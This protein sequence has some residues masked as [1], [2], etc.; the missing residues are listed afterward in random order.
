M[1]RIVVLGAGF[2]GLW[3]AIG[4][5]RKRDE[6]GA[7]GR[8]IE[9]RVVDRNPY[10]NIR[11]RNY[12]VDLSEVA[13]PLGQLL[14]PIG[15]THGLGE[16]EAID[17]ARREISL[18]TSDG[19]ETL[20]YDRLVLA[21]GS[22][23]T[24]P[25]IPGLADHAFDVDT[26]IA[27]LRLEDHLVSLGRSVPSPGR[28]TVVVVGAG[29]TGI[30]VAAEMPDRLARAGITGSRCIILVDPN[31]TVGATIGAHARPVIETALSALDI[32][33][34]LGARV[35]SVEA[36]GVQLSSGEFIPAQ[37][38]IWCAGLRASRLAASLPGA[39]DRLGRL[40]VDPFMRVADLPCV[41]AAGDVAS[42]VVDGLHP[43][44]MSCQF[45]RP[46]GRFAGHNVVADLLG[47][48][49]LPL[50]IDWYVTVLDLG[51]WGALYTEGWDREVRTTGA[52]AKATKQT[53]NRKRIYPP[54]NGSKD[55]LFAAAAP[56]V[57]TPPP[58]YGAR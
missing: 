18:V 35:A 3:A 49:M 54:L 56:T 33:T 7:A 20:G 14:D 37:T 24:R 26:Y 43:T 8:D 28:S 22:E 11:V 42:S 55:E 19:E 29:F 50:R 30:E 17:P 27:A 38:V 51:S 34:R 10:H 44:V 47:L 21:V 40:L 1:T 48:P 31:P 53:I 46:M 6:I 25:D 15:V 58:T 45:A 13:L 41:F 9:I 39:R 32:E 52:A 2:A 57:Q 5:A 16:V 36:A 23:V 12:E 4:A